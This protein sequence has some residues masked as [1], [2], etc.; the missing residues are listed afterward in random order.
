MWGLGKL[1]TVAVTSWKPSGF[2]SDTLVR[3]TT[4]Y[5]NHLKGGLAGVSIVTPRLFP[6]YCPTLVLSL[7]HVFCNKESNFLVNWKW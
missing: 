1:P 3:V 6:C 7:R 5:N 2:I 4:Q